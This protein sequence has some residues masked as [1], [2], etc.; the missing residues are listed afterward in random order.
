MQNSFNHVNHTP[1]LLFPTCIANGQLFMLVSLTI[2][3]MARHFNKYTKRNKHKHRLNNKVAMQL[4][5][6]NYKVSEAKKHVINLSNRKISDNEYML[7]SR[8]LKFIPTPSVKFAKQ[9]LL[10]DFNEFVR[11]MRCRFLYHNNTEKIHPFKLKTNHTPPIADN[12]LENYIF[13]TKHELTSMQVRKF[14]DNLSRSERLSI[15]S[16]LSDKSIIIKKA[17]KN[18]NVV[19][20]D[21][22]DYI[23]E[24]FRL[25]NSEH[26]IKVESFD[27]ENLRLNINSYVENMH[28]KCILDD[29][30]Y[31][32]LIKG[33][34]N[35]FGPGHMHILPKI[36]RLNQSEINNIIDMGFNI[37]KIIP[38]G[39]PII[40]QIG[41]VTEFVGRYVDHFLVPIV[42]SQQTYI[43]DTADFINKIESIKPNNDC[44]L[45]SFDITNMFT[46]CGIDE[47]LEAVKNAYDN[48]DKI[49]FN[50]RSPPT[51]DLIYLLQLI[52]ENN[53]FDFNGQLFKQTIGA[54]IGAVPSP[55]ICDILMFKIM[56]EILS[57]F[58][59]RKNIFFYG[60]YRD[61]GFL[62]HHGPTEELHEFFKMANS[63]HPLLKFTYEISNTSVNFLDLHQGGKIPY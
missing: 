59:H 18:N 47:L 28:A 20:L 9:S 44:C 41:T 57:K 23:S 53:V 3:D 16:L 61:D 13:L 22:Q 60:R 29:V 35:Q 54:A 14:R 17:D 46:N 42:Q 40:S 2:T 6:L 1:D 12:T 45:C 10:K 30:T 33:K 55:E 4:S 63:H 15:L 56:K 62:I 26:Y 27:V 39:R 52:L 43:K 31:K 48:Y 34:E 8:G 32:Y 7:L 5:K 25:L 50:I 58:T 11:K 21:K 49:K 51:E 37:H 24:G 36:H 38:P 19:I